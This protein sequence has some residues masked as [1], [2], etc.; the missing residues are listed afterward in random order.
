MYMRTLPTICLAEPPKDPPKGQP[1]LQT[2]FVSN[3]I[4]F[5]DAKNNCQSTKCALFVPG[6]LRDQPKLD[7]LVFF[8]GLDT[9]SPKYQSDPQ[10]IINNFKL[11][12]QVNNASRKAALVVPLVMFNSGDRNSGFIRAAWSAAYLNSLVEEALIEIGNRSRVRPTLDRLI[13]AGHSA[14]YEILIPL[15]EQF[16]CGQPE[17]KK[18]ALAKL[19]KVIAFDIP[20]ASRH[21]DALVDWARILPSVQFTLVFANDGGTPPTVW[22]TWRA[23]NRTVKLPTNLTDQKPAHG[24]CQLPPNH[25]TL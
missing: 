10:R 14:G 5:K 21:V 15:A 2:T 18:G 24:H 22:K 1:A 3:V 6:S 19:A 17:T 13:L 16:A 4:T 25:L 9:C 23:N 11:A 12:D 20:H 7:V 8:H